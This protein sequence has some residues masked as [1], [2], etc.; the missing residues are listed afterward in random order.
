MFGLFKKKNKLEDIKDPTERAIV[1]FLK[2]ND[3]STYGDIIKNL[4]L[5]SSAGLKHIFEL[6]EKGII[7]NKIK[8]PFYKLA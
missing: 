6:K 8:P 4:S 2:K 7:S 5:S 3:Y 1:D